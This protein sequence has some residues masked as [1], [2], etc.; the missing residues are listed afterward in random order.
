MTVDRAPPFCR[1]ETWA[2]RCRRESGTQRLG[3][4]GPRAGQAAS[5]PLVSFFSSFFS[6]GKSDQGT[7][8]SFR[9]CSRLITD[10]L[11]TRYRMKTWL[12]GSLD[13][14]Y[15]LFI[16]V[17]RSFPKFATHNTLSSKDRDQPRK[18]FNRNVAYRKYR[19]TYTRTHT[20]RKSFGAV[21]SLAF[22]RY[23]CRWKI[24][25]GKFQKHSF[26]K[27]PHMTLTAV[28]FRPWITIFDR[29]KLKCNAS[30][31]F[32]VHDHSKRKEKK[33]KYRLWSLPMPSFLPSP[34]LYY[35]SPRGF[36]PCCGWPFFPLVLGTVRK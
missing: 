6:G 19:K 1:C 28:V 7:A 8:P 21:L 16:I 27:V 3:A 10:P 31:C 32:A 33:H 30:T 9:T 18:A 35:P 34:L 24:V 11:H 36:Q 15:I 23:G 17:E 4:T 29:S 25:P 14:K 26:V 5:T 22:W 12:S 13:T 20:N 2:C